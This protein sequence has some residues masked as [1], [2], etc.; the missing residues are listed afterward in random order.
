MPAICHI[1]P[2]ARQAHGKHYTFLPLSG[3]LDEATL[4]DFSQAVEPLLESNHAYLVLD[5]GELDLVSSHAVGYL[6][7]MHRKMEQSQKQMVFVNANK[8]VR[9]ILDFIGLAKLIRM[10][11]AEE[12]FLEALKNE[13]I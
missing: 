10:F 8:E 13:E 4:P 6:E 3:Y 11:V 7:N 12:H 2:Q 9:E 5:L 1:S